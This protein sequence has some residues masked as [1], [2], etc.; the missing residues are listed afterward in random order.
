MEPPSAPWSL[1]EVSRSK[2]NGAD[3]TKSNRKAF[4]SHWGLR[5]K[6]HGKVCSQLP[7]IFSSVSHISLLYGTNNLSPDSPAMISSTITEILFLL[8]RKCPT[9][10]IHLFPKTHFASTN[11]CIYFQVLNFFQDLFFLHELQSTVYNQNLFRADKLHLTTKG[12]KILVRWFHHCLTMSTSTS[13]EPNP[14]PCPPCRMLP[15]LLSSQILTAPH[16][17]PAP[18]QLTNPT[19]PPP[20]RYSKQHLT[21]CTCT[22]NSPKS[23]PHPI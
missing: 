5:N 23:G 9:A 18:S 2:R 1:E 12:N 4:S 3:L 15:L 20:C 16:P 6:K 7:P 21:P 14:L 17:L 19:F 11:S 13:L 10:N 8:R 22:S